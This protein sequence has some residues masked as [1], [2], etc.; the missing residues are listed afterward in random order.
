MSMSFSAAPAAAAVA[1]SFARPSGAPPAPVVETRMSEKL[2][3]PLAGWADLLV[4][5]DHPARSVRTSAGIE[6]NMDR[7][8]VRFVAA[9]VV[10]LSEPK[11]KASETRP[12]PDAV[13]SP[14]LRD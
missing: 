8:L 13:A 1:W 12:T 10:P 4:V 14:Q 6:D 11:L 5:E 3:P 9:N 2:K 7:L